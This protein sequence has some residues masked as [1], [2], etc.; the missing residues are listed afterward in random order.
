M[1]FVR[2]TPSPSWLK[3]VGAAPPPSVVKAPETDQA[4]A[5]PLA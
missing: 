5:N 4:L 1:R 3:D 2:I